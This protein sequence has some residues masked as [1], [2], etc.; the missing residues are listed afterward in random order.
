MEYVHSILSNVALNPWLLAVYGLTI[1]SLIGVWLIEN[2]NVWRVTG[3]LA[4]FI[5]LAVD[6]VSLIALPSLLLLLIFTT[7]LQFDKNRAR[8]GIWRLSVVILPLVIALAFSGAFSTWTLLDGIQ[9]GHSSSSYA[10]NLNMSKALIALILLATVVPTINCWTDLSQMLK[11]TIPIFAIGLPA[12]VAFSSAVGYTQFDFKLQ[13][14]IFAWGTVNLFLTCIGEEVFFRGIVLKQLMHSFEPFKNGNY[15]ALALSSIIFGI[16]HFN[17][18]LI[19]ILV[20]TSAGLLYGAAYIKTGKVEASIL[21]HFGI[22][23]FH[24]IFLTYPKI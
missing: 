15:L 12:V 1:F 14:I 11:K 18:G 5:A 20:A 19:F 22:N 21:C 2:K 6:H 16:V 9:L 7:A 4:L 3:I 17:G 24:F 23:V 8:Q 13:P 10:I